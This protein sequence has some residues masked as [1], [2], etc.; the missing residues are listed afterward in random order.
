MARRND[1]SKNDNGR[2]NY[3]TRYMSRKVT[4]HV[5]EK[6]D[7]DKRIADYLSKHPIKVV[8]YNGEIIEERWENNNE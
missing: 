8:D 6:E 2:T 1:R 7:Y 4:E 3:N 5:L